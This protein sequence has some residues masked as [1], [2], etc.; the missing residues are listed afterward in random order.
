METES[1]IKKKGNIRKFLPYYKPYLGLFGF[2]LLCAL[3]ATCVELAFP[4]L[5]KLITNGVVGSS[6]P[7]DYTFLF[8]I[9]GIMLGLRLVE[10]GCR[11]YIAKYGHIMGARIETDL[12]STLFRHLQELPHAYYDNAKVGSLM[13]RIST[14][15]FDITEFSHHCPEE[16]FIAGLKIAG[17][18]TILAV[19]NIWLALIVFAVVPL[20]AW[21]AV[22]FNGKMRGIFRESRITMG[23]INSQVEDSLSGIRVV[24]SFTNE[25][26]E[27]R[28]FEK[29]NENFLR[30]KKKN[31]HYMGAFTAGMKFFDGLMYI[32]IILVCVVLKL[33]A[34]TFT[35]SLLYAATLLA[36]IRALADYTEQFQKG[37]TAFERFQEI[38]DTPNTLAEN[39]GAQDIDVVKGE[40]EFKD[41][42][43][44]YEQANEKVL[45]KMTM[46]IGSGEVVAIVGP[47]GSGKTTVANLIP[48]F[49]DVEEGEIL[50]D[51]VSVKNYSLKSLRGNVGVVAQDVY[52]FWGTI[53][54]NIAY[55]KINSTREKI[56]AAAKAADVHEF[57]SK[58]PNGYDSMVGERG[59][60]LSGGQ[61]QRIS[62][63]RVFLKNPPILVL[64]E[65]TSSLDNESEAMVQASLDKLS[66]GRTCIIIAHRLSTIKNADKIVVLTED[67]IEEIGT[68]NELISHDG[69]YKKL[70][71]LSV[72][73]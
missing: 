65:A 19:T 49:Y 8:T 64:D 53:A 34:G 20:M 50:I 27:E 48:R 16:F 55:G 1:E 11:F 41:I 38:M 70:Y 67:G 71:N 37:M 44:S 40:I 24:K 42:T 2:D 12:R 52:L 10:V 45:K 9:V 23:E 3:V 46:K 54:E 31:Y 51:G 22:R 73:K 39:D 4:T 29:G 28:K 43:F 57:V 62:I 6:D 35:S 63:A 21:F 18:F 25:N 14:D 60:K 32:V 68:H 5:V 13:S 66:R 15:L 58:L 26:V 17:V 56:I 59:I 69:T 36:T 30:L 7:V 72:S 47:S 61:K 33:D